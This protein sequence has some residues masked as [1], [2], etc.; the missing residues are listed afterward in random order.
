MTLKRLRPTMF[1]RPGAGLVPL[2]L[3]LLLATVGGLFY[4]ASRRDDSARLALL[5]A[6]TVWPVPPDRLQLCR[7]ALAAGAD[8]NALFS[9]EEYDRVNVNALPTNL[10]VQV[11]VYRLW[12]DT[13]DF[14][15]RRH[16]PT[17]ANYRKQQYSALYKAVEGGDVSVA[18]LLLVK[19]ADPNRR[20]AAGIKTPLTL[21]V[22]EGDA[23]LTR[24]LLSHGADPTLADGRGHTP[25]QAA[26]SC[27]SGAVKRLVRDALASKAT[28]SIASSKRP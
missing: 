28:K 20:V 21:A 12:I 22:F 18:S 11:R 1:P 15:T 27:G 23:A 24:L 17:N 8:P 6:V 16:P 26:S 25:S 19:G 2:T 10:K 9:D 5:R 3:A 4:Q 7:D 14:A 13:L